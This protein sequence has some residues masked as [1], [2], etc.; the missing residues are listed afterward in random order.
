VSL[1]AAGSDGACGLC[2]LFTLCRQR[3]WAASAVIGQA[4]AD[5]QSASTRLPAWVGCLVKTVYG[6][7]G[8]DNVLAQ[9]STTSPAQTLQAQVDPDIT[10]TGM[11]PTTSE[12]T[13]PA[14]PPVP[15]PYLIA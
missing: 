13:P 1:T 10:S 14:L 15:A 9:L 6:P 7:P 11:G 12:S 3:P 8:P 4:S 2:G 5:G